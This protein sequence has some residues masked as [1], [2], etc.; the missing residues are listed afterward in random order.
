MF[1]R[2]FRGNASKLAGADRAGADGAGRSGRAGRTV[3][4]AQAGP[5]GRCWP[6]RPGRTDGAG[7]RGRP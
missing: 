3:L 7:H 4:A 6:L 5:D 1:T 2:R